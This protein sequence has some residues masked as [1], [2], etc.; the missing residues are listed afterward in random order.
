MTTRRTFIKGIGAGLLLPSTWDLF[1]NHME[2][3]GEPL[4]VRPKTVTDILYASYW[5]DDFQ[6]SLNSVDED[7]P[8]P[9]MSIK[10]FITDHAGGED[11]GCW[12]SDDYNDPIGDWFVTE[13]WP[14][15]YSASARAFYCLSS[16]DLGLLRDSTETESGYIDF[17]E[18]P[19][20]G[21]DSR[22]VCADGLGVSLLQQRLTEYGHNFGFVFT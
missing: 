2:Q 19:C 10:Q 15:H 22:F 11:P 16:L 18:G 17:V 9:Q 21:N 7:Y 6:L 1:A 3:F 8:C 14:Y 20:P 13:I 12:E 5:G 4:L